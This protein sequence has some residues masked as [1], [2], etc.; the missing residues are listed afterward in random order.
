[1]TNYAKNQIAK[2]ETR[3]KFPY[4]IEITSENQKYYYANC[5]ENVVYD[6]H[7]YLASFF[8]VSLPDKTQNGFS[9][10]KLSISAV[11]QQWIVRT[12]Q[13][14]ER[15]KV[16]FVAT[17]NYVAN[18]QQVVEPIEELEFMISLASW[19]PSTIEW[20][21]KFDELMELQYCAEVTGIICPALQ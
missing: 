15:A 10:A 7:T 6:G 13:T 1:M 8:K 4:L 3:A 11:D 18:S 17:I 21:M 16:K 9:D 20:T 19:T 5:D 2:M 12:R 14:D